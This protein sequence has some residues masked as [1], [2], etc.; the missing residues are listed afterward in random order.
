M[1]KLKCCEVTFSKEEYQKTLIE[2]NTMHE[3]PIMYCGK[4][5]YIK[6]ICGESLDKQDLEIYFTPDEVH[7]ILEMII[8]CR[9]S[10]KMSNEE[11]VEKMEDDKCYLIKDETPCCKREIKYKEEYIKKLQEEFQRDPSCREL[12]SC[13]YCQ[14]IVFKD[15][16]KQILTDKEIASIYVPPS[17]IKPKTG[18]YSCCSCYAE[19]K[20]DEEYITF[21]CK[22]RYHAR[23]ANMILD[24]SSTNYPKCPVKSCQQTIYDSRTLI[25]KCEA[26]M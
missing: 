5:H 15:N 13:P 14:K 8:Q 17:D 2:N 20:K 9:S 3:E 19:F 1:I 26:I 10:A 6:C 22:H 11:G 24:N 18:N 25:A 23:C 7:Y 4:I 16:L 12:L 21:E